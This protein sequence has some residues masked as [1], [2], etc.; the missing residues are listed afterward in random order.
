MHFHAVLSGHAKLGITPVK[1]DTYIVISAVQKLQK[2]LDRSGTFSTAP[3]KFLAHQNIWTQ[4][5]QLLWNQRKPKLELDIWVRHYLV[6]QQLK[7]P[8]SKRQLLVNKSEGQI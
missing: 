8:V 5:R 6:W 1:V 2:W 7:Q 3:P 4:E